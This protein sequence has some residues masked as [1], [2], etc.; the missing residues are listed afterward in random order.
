MT[1]SARILAGIFSERGLTVAGRLVGARD[2]RL[3]LSDFDR[4][5]PVREPSALRFL[6]IPELNA[7]E[8]KE[9]SLDSSSSSKDHPIE[10][11]L[12]SSGLCRELKT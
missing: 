10:G 2:K 5:R 12:S 1:M 3:F 9:E 11:K 4:T 8:S 7:V 6:D